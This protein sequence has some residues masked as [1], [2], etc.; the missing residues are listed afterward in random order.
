MD[1][2]L[3]YIEKVRQIMS[4]IFNVPID[5]ITGNSSQETIEKWDSLGHLNLIISLEEEFNIAFSSEEIANM[6]SVKSII[7]T[8]KKYYK[9]S[10]FEK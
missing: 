9:G 5:E 8:I 3:K 1:K 2:E 4:Q 10:G 6:P 7:S